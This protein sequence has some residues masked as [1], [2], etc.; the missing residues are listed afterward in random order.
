ME[1][2]LF[3]LSY[4]QIHFLSNLHLDQ[5]AR[6]IRSLLHIVLLL[7]IAFYGDNQKYFFEKLFLCSWLQ[8][9]QFYTQLHI[10]FLFFQRRS[11]DE[12]NPYR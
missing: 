2:Y 3:Q 4:S 7:Q 11:V 6:Y 5:Q 12:V 10:P 9:D 8:V 1:E